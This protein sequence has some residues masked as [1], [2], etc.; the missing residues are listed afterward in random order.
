MSSRKRKMYQ[1][2]NNNHPYHPSTK[3]K[4]LKSEIL[5]PVS[6]RKRQRS[7][8]SNN[9]NNHPSSKRFKPNPSHPKNNT[10]KINKNKNN[11]AGLIRR[12]EKM[13]ITSPPKLS[14]KSFNNMSNR[15]PNPKSFKNQRRKSL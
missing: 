13:R 4:F 11:I 3:L 14:I 12:M 5:N 9:N 6:S 15:N 10:T 2:P 1:N 7:P 8:N